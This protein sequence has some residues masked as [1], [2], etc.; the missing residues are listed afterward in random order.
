M[1]LGELRPAPGSTRDT[2]RKGRG[3][4]TGLGRTA[5][6]GNKGAGQR[7]GNKRRA[8]FEGGQMPLVRRVPKR[9][10]SNYP[11]RKE[12][13]IVNVSDLERIEV[14]DITPAEMKAA[15]LIRSAYQPVKVLGNGEVSRAVNVTAS[16]F[17]QSAR[18]KI[19][20]KGGTATV[21]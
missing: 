11:F 1:K 12:F 9:G 16:A 4:G 15:G 13:Q 21:L 10:F 3:H 20:Q 18:E 2:K 17:S 19:T 7:S 5:G 8:W 14:Q 6:R